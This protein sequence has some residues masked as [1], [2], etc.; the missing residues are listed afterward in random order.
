MFDL[1]ELNAELDTLEPG[2]LMRV[3]GLPDDVYH[4]SKGFGSSKL[5]SFI[6]CPALFKA[7]LDGLHKT[8]ASMVIG[9]AFHMA[10]L[11]PER[12]EQR[13]AVAPQV[14]KRT[15]AGKAVWE[16]LQ[17]SGLEVLSPADHAKVLAMRDSCRAKFGEYLQHGMPEVSFFRKHESG[18]ILKARVD[19]LIGDLA[20]DLKSTADVFEFKRQARQYG[21]DWQAAHYLWVCSGEVAEMVFLPTGN[22]EPYLS[23]TPLCI[24]PTRLHDRKM[25]WNNACFE[26]ARCLAA[27][28]WPGL[29]DEPEYLD[30]KPWEA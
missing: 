1:N 30:L 21:Y 23:G 29:S 3:D 7:E 6:K 26:L 28:T 19:W 4:A 2:T 5:K 10:V 15:K 12:F 13:Y 24:D 20:V 22:S 17:A 8:S 16:E 11:E 18:L 9:S 27:D 14:D 25:R